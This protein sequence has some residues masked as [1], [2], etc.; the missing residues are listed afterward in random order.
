MLTGNR[1]AQAL[2]EHLRQNVDRIDR[3]QTSQGRIMQL[4]CQAARLSLSLFDCSD[5]D[6]CRVLSFP[7][8]PHAS[9]G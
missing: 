4:W 5:I 8:L 1:I 7:S 3:Q 6:S 9:L 2:A